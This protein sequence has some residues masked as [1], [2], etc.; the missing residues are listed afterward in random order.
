MRRSIVCAFFAGSLGLGLVAM[1][2]AVGAGPCKPRLDIKDVQFSQMEPPS[3]ERK[4]TAL[5]VVD[6]SGCAANAAGY[7]EIV[8]VRSLE[9]GPE[10]EFREQFI[11]MPPSVK[12]GVDFGAYESVERYR[13]DNVTS[14]VCR[15]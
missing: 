11:W 9:I 7:F 13:I 10:L 15:D 14:C 8:F 5:V 4:W 2:G 6:T 1:A 12:V 3:M